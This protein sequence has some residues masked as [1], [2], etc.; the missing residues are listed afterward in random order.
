MEPDLCALVISSWLV[1]TVKRPFKGVLTFIVALITQL[2]FIWYMCVAIYEGDKTACGAPALLQFFG[3]FTFGSACVTE[4]KSAKLMLVALVCERLRVPA[5]PVPDASGRLTLGSD[6]IIRVRK[7]SG[8]ARVLLA[9]APL[10]EMVVEVMTLLV[11]AA[12][13]VLSENVEELILNA[14]AVNFV[15]QI[16]DMMLTA[17]VN[18]ASRERL[19]KYQYE[20]PFGV[21]EG[22]TTLKNVSAT[23]RRY[24]R[25]QE[26][27]P[28]V[29]LLLCLVGVGGGQWWSRSRGD[30]S[31]SWVFPTFE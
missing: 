27:I 30:S 18:K 3:L 16:D 8:R 24:A 5:T 23:S 11:G 26:F 31:C 7:T 13:L 6:Q 21:E 10:L 2:G 15:T 28:L 19:A 1:P 4:L 9:L 17:F 29:V 12:Y 25:A 22:D 20:Q 14:V